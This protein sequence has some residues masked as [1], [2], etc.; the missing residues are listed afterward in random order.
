MV[1]PVWAWQQERMVH[2]L[3]QALH[4]RPAPIVHLFRFPRVT[5]NHGIVLFGANESEQA[6]QFEAYDPNIPE[7]PV[8]LIYERAAR[9]F[10]F[11]KAHYWAGG[12]V[13]VIEVYRGGLY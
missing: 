5:I 11:P 10:Y 12:R 7:H 6:I 8:K 1:F 9:A 4:K 13:S 2:Q 3:K